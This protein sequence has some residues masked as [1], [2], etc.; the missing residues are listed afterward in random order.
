MLTTGVDAHTINDT[1][2]L[3]DKRFGTVFDGKFITYNGVNIVEVSELK[4]INTAQKSKFLSDYLNNDTYKYTSAEMIRNT[5]KDYIVMCDSTDDAEKKKINIALLMQ[6]RHLDANYVVDID[7]KL[8][9]I[10]SV[11]DYKEIT[12]DVSINVDALIRIHNYLEKNKPSYTETNIHGYDTLLKAIAKKY[13]LYSLFV[14]TNN[15][16]MNRGIK[17]KIDTKLRELGKTYIITKFNLTNSGTKYVYNGVDIITELEMSNLLSNNEKYYKTK[18]KNYMT[19]YLQEDTSYDNAEIIKHTLKEYN[20]LLEEKDTVEKIKTKINRLMKLKCENENYVI[21][22]GNKWYPVIS[23]AEYAKLTANIDME[24]LDQIYKYLNKHKQEHMEKISDPDIKINHV[25]FKVAMTRYKLYSLFVTSYG[26]KL[27]E[28]ERELIKKKVMN[29]NLISRLTELQRATKKG[30]DVC[31]NLCKLVNSNIK[32]DG[33]GVEGIISELELKETDIQSEDSHE[34]IPKDHID[35]ILSHIKTHT[36]V[37]NDYKNFRNSDDKN[38]SEF[39]AKIKKNQFNSL[40]CVPL[41]LVGV[42]KKTMRE[43]DDD[44]IKNKKLIDN[45][46][47]KWKK[48]ESVLGEKL[49]IMKKEIYE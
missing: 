23:F 31:D 18:M 8:H 40:L 7:G 22:S 42:T 47:G 44:M 15:K 49:K 11:D 36:H 38:I 45:E 33:G 19:Y 21:Y 27:L 4:G 25:P 17:N 3:I 39:V 20:I 29:Q 2:Q 13:K 34:H 46:L 48:L 12:S 28:L 32:H 5:I 37:Y 26:E 16:K 43:I 1:L 24:T 41:S 30:N 6:L 10:I 14:I 9:N 35:K